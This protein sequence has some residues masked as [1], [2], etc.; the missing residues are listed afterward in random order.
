M[1]ILTSCSSEDFTEPIT[2]SVDYTISDFIPATGEA[3]NAKPLT[4]SEEDPGA[5]R[6]LTATSTNGFDWIRTNEE[7][8]DR[9]GAPEAVVDNEGRIFL[10]Y[11]SGTPGL[12]NIWVA[13]VSE[14]QGLTW[15]H[16][17]VNVQGVPTG[18]RIVDTSTILL[19]DGTFRSYFQ[20]HFPGD[21][22]GYIRSATSSDGLNWQLEEG[23]RINELENGDMPIAPNVLVI[24]GIV[25]M[26]VHY[27]NAK[28]KYDQNLHLTSVDGLLFIE[29]AA[30]NVGENF[31]NHV[32]VNGQA[33][34]YGFTIPEGN[35]PFKAALYYSTTQDGF[36]FTQ[37]TLM[38]QVDSEASNNLE[39]FMLKEPTV[40]QLAGGSFLMFYL[41]GFHE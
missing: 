37:A 25:H 33:I 24:D 36:E 23:I 17:Y 35:D 31:A 40:V 20:S 8:I 28:D 7:F 5:L 4:E 15:V 32:W 34:S 9:V 19:G 13:A 12:E 27:A 41:T 26:Y 39:F 16:K 1:L 6:L 21:A 22:H 18:G 11:V 38:M 3:P 29:D 30:V 10:Y 14:D 2:N